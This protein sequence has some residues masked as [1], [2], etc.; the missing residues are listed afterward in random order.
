MSE[1]YVE[2]THGDINSEVGSTSDH[3]AFMEL[4]DF[5]WEDVSEEIGRFENFNVNMEF[6]TSEWRS[7]SKSLRNYIT[8]NRILSKV[9]SNIVPMSNS[10]NLDTE[11]KSSEDGNVI[12]RPYSL[13]GTEQ[14]SVESGN[15]EIGS[16]M[17]RI[18]SNLMLGS[19]IGQTS[20]REEVTTN[21]SAG[22]QSDIGQLSN[23]ETVPG[24]F[25]D[26]MEMVV[27]KKDFKG[28]M[29]IISQRLEQIPHDLNAHE[30]V[31]KNE[32]AI[33]GV[34]LKQDIVEEVGTVLRTALTGTAIAPTL[35]HSVDNRVPFLPS[36]PSGLVTQ[37]RLPNGLNSPLPTGYAMQAP[38]G[39]VM[40]QRA[41]SMLS[42]PV[43]PTTTSGVSRHLMYGSGVP[44]APIASILR[45]HAPAYEPPVLKVII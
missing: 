39:T 6:T 27:L 45:P 35:G 16:S 21:K 19:D 7:L 37:I 36:T 5:V 14:Q 8:A 4:V 11:A 10:P 24:D 25:E 32:F 44:S 29:D 13:S 22:A 34:N 2:D 23:T 9:T 15:E 3:S 31:M 20:I 26:L 28:S 42:S 12:V 1:D 18:A 17:Q 33:M 41:M 40:S 30:V 38:M 43:M